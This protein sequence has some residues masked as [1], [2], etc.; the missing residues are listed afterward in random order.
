MTLT[1][2]TLILVNTFDFTGERERTANVW[3]LMANAAASLP[4]EL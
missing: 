4:Q 3:M 1:F 2:F